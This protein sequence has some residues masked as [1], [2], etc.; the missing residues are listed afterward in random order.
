MAARGTVTDVELLLNPSLWTAV[1]LVGLAETAPC[2]PRYGLEVVE[3]A[4]VYPNQDPD[5]DRPRVLQGGARE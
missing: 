2:P 1:E 5:A 4:V 3:E